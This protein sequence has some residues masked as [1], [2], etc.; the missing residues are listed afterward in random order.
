LDFSR[1]RQILKEVDLLASCPSP[2]KTFPR[3][4]IEFRGLSESSDR[5]SGSKSR[6]SPN[7]Y[8]GRVIAL[9]ALDLPLPKSYLF[10]RIGPSIGYVSLMAIPIPSAPAPRARLVQILLYSPLRL[11]IEDQWLSSCQSLFLATSTEQLFNF[12]FRKT[13][14]FFAY[15]VGLFVSK[16]L[17]GRF[18]PDHQIN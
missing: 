7:F 18:P 2:L 3:T 14:P 5:R 9:A 6:P 10:T 12:Q 8:E 17:A 16:D 1:L 4:S 15:I 11:G 13:L